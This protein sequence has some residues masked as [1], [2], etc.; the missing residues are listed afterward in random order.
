MHR[1]VSG[2]EWMPDPSPSSPMNTSKASTPNDVSMCEGL[3]KETD[4]EVLRRRGRGPRRVS[5]RGGEAVERGAQGLSKASALGAS[6]D[7]PR[8]HCGPAGN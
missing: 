6:G 8:S 2:V 3:G 1:Y 4:L 7:R 5:R